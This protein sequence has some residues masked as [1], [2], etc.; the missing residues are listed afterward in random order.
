MK[1]GVGVTLISLV[2]LGGCSEGSK[3]PNDAAGTGAA[4][5]SAGTS[6]GGGANGTGGSSGTAGSGGG[7]QACMGT[8][9]PCAQLSPAACQNTPGCARG[10]CLGICTAS[11]VTDCATMA[12]CTWDGVQCVRMSA[13]C[14]PF[15]TSPTYCMGQ[16]GCVFSNA[17]GC[18][19]P[20]RPCSGLTPA[21][22]AVQPG[23]MLR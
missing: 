6:G 21:E 18:I 22:C 9:T 15:N 23:C 14:S 12:G 17:G 8:S 11:G 4:T 13:S 2:V 20:A 7:G 16:S 1:L 3:M 19:G 10:G 5:G